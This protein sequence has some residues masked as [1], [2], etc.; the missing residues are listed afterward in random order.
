M[1]KFGRKFL[2]VLWNHKVAIMWCIAIEPLA[3][4]TSDIH[5]LIETSAVLQ[6]LK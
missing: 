2:F 3:L 4:R 6:F 1:V 5:L